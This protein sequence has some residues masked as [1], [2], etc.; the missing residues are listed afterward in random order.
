MLQPDGGDRGSASAGGKPGGS[1]KSSGASKPGGSPS[2][3]GAPSGRLPKEIRDKGIVTIGSDI[4]Y[5]P[6]EFVR[7]SKP[8]VSTP[9]SRTQRRDPRRRHCPRT[10]R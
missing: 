6:M 2:A 4:A 3:I 1:R 5:P 9:T 10:Q 7:D 8:P